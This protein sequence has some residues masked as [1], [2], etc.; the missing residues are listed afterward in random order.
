MS[1]VASVVV[2]TKTN[3]VR[4]MVMC[5]LTEESSSTP[6][7]PVTRKGPHFASGI[8]AWFKPQNR[9][10]SGDRFAAKADGQFRSF[11]GISFDFDDPIPI[12]IPIPS[13]PERDGADGNNLLCR[14][15]RKSPLDVDLSSSSHR[16]RTDESTAVFSLEWW[17]KISRSVC[18]IW[19]ENPETLM[20]RYSCEAITKRFYSTLV[21]TR[22]RNKGDTNPRDKRVE[23]SSRGYST[24]L[25]NSF[26]HYKL[27]RIS[28]SRYPLYTSWISFFILERV[29]CAFIRHP[30][31][32][33]KSASLSKC[34]TISRGY[35]SPIYLDQMMWRIRLTT[36]DLEH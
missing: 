36:R 28:Q 25:Y 10:V 6:A 34:T 21:Y 16:F 19:R 5:N 31:S 24:T 3:Y 4:T 22:W 35:L 20:H 1:T 7:T 13:H 30:T 29:L 15:V 17:E 2:T 27:A 8:F 14:L 32:P 9:P 23:S 33:K 18:I 26:S 12:S 11:K